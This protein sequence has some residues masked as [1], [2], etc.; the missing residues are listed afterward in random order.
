MSQV[1]SYRR[2]TKRGTTTV[3]MHY[4]K[5]SATKKQRANNVHYRL[6]SLMSLHVIKGGSKGSKRY[7]TLAARQ[8][9][10]SR[11]RR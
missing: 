11:Y 3:L 4:R 5:S 10:V 6:Q 9:A 2:R 1:K 7:K 8:K